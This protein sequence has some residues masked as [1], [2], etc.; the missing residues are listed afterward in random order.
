VEQSGPLKCLELKFPLPGNA[1]YEM[2]PNLTSYGLEIRAFD[3][4]YQILFDLSSYF[5]LPPFPVPEEE[6]GSKQKERKLKKKDI[7]KRR[8]GVNA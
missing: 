4:R 7:K 3:Q 2:F 8:G 1:Y 6:E 5:L